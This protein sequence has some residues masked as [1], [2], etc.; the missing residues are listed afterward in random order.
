M[1]GIDSNDSGLVKPPRRHTRSP[2]T[3]T[4]FSRPTTFTETKVS[5]MGRPAGAQARPT[6][7]TSV[8]GLADV[9]ISDAY[10]KA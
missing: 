5:V 2:T 3:R 10:L 6:T 7:T 1:S 4:T 9:W 8:V